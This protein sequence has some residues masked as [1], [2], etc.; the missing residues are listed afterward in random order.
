MIGGE[1]D[2]REDVSEKEGRMCETEGSDQVFA[3]SASKL[4]DSDGGSAGEWRGVE[5][6]TEKRVLARCTVYRYAGMQAGFGKKP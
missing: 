1:G 5:L 6:E 4:A 2:T 3:K